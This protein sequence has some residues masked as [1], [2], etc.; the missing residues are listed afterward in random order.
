ML[1]YIIYNIY[2]QTAKLEFTTGDLP[3]SP[4]TT[5]FD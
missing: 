5:P 3:S 4:A 1:Y 2:S